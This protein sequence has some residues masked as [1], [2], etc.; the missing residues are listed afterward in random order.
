MISGA[1]LESAKSAGERHSGL[2]IDL[3]LI[4]AG[5]LDFN[6]ILDGDDIGLRLIL[7]GKKGVKCGRLTGTGR[8]RNQA[9]S[10]RN[11]DDAVD[12]HV[13]MGVDAQILTIQ[14]GIV[15]RED[16]NNRLLAVNRRQNGDRMSTAYR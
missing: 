3:D 16:T 14:V 11:L 5:D 13:V 10:L 7:L 9:D 8:S 6:R 1:R 4:D 2:N 15:L 12:H